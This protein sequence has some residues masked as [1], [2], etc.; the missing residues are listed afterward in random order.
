ML[1]KTGGIFEQE[2]NCCFVEA[3]ILRLEIARRG[4]K[5]LCTFFPRSLLS[6]K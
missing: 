3:A 2:T 6:G 1:I 4:E 5:G